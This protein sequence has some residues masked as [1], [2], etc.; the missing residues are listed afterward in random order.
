MVGMPA[1]NEAENIATAVENFL[2]QNTVDE[3][4]V[5]DNNSSDN[6]AELAE[7]AGATVVSET[8]QGYGYACQRAFQEMYEHDSDLLVLVEPDGTF[9]ADDIE[10]LLSYSSDFDFVVGTRTS[11]QLIWEG[12]NMDPFLRWGNW[13]VGKLVEVLHNT[14][15]LTDVGCTFRLIKA[16]AYEDIRHRFRIGGSHFSPH[17]LIEAAREDISMIEIPVN[18]RSRKGTSKITGERWPAFKLGLVMI[19]LVVSEWYSDN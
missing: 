4:V 18:Y 2:A 11:P 6:T 3:V 8:R 13:F 7:E 9:V 1:Y 14:S 17:M 16:D 5:V 19:W 12:A 15:N 10:K